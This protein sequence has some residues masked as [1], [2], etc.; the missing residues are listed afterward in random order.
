MLDGTDARIAYLHTATS[1]SSS[2]SFNNHFALTSPT[3]PLVSWQLHHATATATS[4]SLILTHSRPAVA[5]IPLLPQVPH[6]CQDL[7]RPAEGNHQG[8]RP[9]A[10]GQG[11]LL[12]SISDACCLFALRKHVLH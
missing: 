3:S 6:H 12:R 11:A 5:A 10:L 4:A 1:S 8:H 2:S 7:G 9:G